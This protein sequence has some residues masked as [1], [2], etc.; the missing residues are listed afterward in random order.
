MSAPTSPTSGNAPSNA[1]SSAPNENMAHISPPVPPPDAPRTEVWSP[2]PPAPSTPPRRKANHP[3][4]IIAIVAIVILAPVMLCV[5]AA[6]VAGFGGF[7][8]SRLTEQTATSNLQVAVPDHPTITIS[9]T[10]GQVAITRGAVQQV[11]V[12]ATKRA[13][14]LTSAAARDMLDAMTVTAVP[15]PGGARITATTGPSGA[16]NQRTVDLRITVP[17]T[18]DLRVTVNAGTLTIVSVTGNIN[19][20]MNA[21][22]VDLRDVVAQGATTLDVS[23]GTLNFSGALA[24]GSNV[25]ATVATGNANITLP[26]TS[27]TH[28]T[29]S[30]NVGSISVSPWAAT[31]QHSGTGQSTEL[32]LNTP[33]TSALKAHVDVGAI[34]I[35]AR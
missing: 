13:H 23:T 9:A 22:T 10:A 15:E 1:P 12:V 24:D 6:L 34:K 14:A 35:V 7:L 3:A 31:I 2:A 8:A 28:L 4:L 11:S 30:T 20:T 18:S 27:A 33:T 32:D 26:T 25:T 17:Q 5:G 16:L 21:G 29:A 19:L